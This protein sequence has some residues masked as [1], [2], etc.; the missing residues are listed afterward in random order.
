[1]VNRSNNRSAS[2]FRHLVID[3]KPFDFSEGFD[4][5]HAL[6]Y[7]RI[8]EGNGFSLRDTRPSIETVC[9]LRKM[10]PSEPDKRAHPMVRQ[11]LEDR[12]K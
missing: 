4:D 12:A 10:S 5:L 9:N 7:K 1:M 11:I 3:G 2:P 8:I 6:S